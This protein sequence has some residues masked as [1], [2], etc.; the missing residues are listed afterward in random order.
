MSRRIAR[1]V[2][3]VNENIIQDGR[4]LVINEE[5]E[6]HLSWEHIPDG[7]IKINPN[8]GMIYVKVKDQSDW[9]PAGIKNDGTI[10]IAKDTFVIEETFTVKTLDDGNGEFSYYNTEGE[11]RHGQKLENGSFVFE[12][13]KGSYPM[14]RNH[15]EIIIDDA[16]RR[17]ASSGGVTEISNTKFA[18]TEKLVEEQEITARYLSS[19]RIGNPYPRIFLTSDE[20]EYAETGDF[21]LDYDDSL[22]NDDII[23][24]NIEADTTIGW[25]RITGRP[26]TINGYGITDEISYKGHKHDASDILNLKEPTSIKANGGNADTVNHYTADSNKP[27]TLAILDLS[28]KISNANIG[29]HFHTI[30]DLIDVDKIKANGGNSDTV[31]HY[32][33]NN[34]NPNTLAIL[35]SNG[36]IPANNIANHT[37]SMNE[38]TNLNTK[39]S[40]LENSINSLTT[41]GM[42][43]LWYGSK[44]TPPNGWTVCDGQNGTPDLKN[45]FIIGSSDTC[46]LGNAA[47]EV[48]KQ[49]STVSESTVYSLYYIMKL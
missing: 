43:M 13:E 39:I 26:T 47:I 33:V 18:I 1:G 29:K 46:P 23:G 7:S 49:D 22:N 27:N 35:D 20:P 2:R 34:N 44:N 6:K 32:T 14:L 40:N 41:R 8:T 42:I 10:S 24:D 36:K 48:N 12:L 9:I 45:K 4:S 5:N 38:I 11:V 17:T 16:L 30:T 31:N 37:H 28:G 3:K 21:W 25:N 19:N 15:L